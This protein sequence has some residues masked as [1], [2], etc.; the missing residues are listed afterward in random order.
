[1]NHPGSDVSGR[2]REEAGC[3]ILAFFARVGTTVVSAAPP[4][5]L[6]TEYKTPQL[7]SQLLDL[8]GIAGRPKALRQFGKRLFLLAAGFNPLFDQ[9]D[10]DTVVAQI[11]LPGDGFDLLRNFCGKGNAST[12]PSDR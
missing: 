8:L 5:S 11:A 2:D 1:M 4:L 12:N 3:P 10:Q 9:F 7:V 6:L